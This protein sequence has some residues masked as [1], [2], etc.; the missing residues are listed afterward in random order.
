[1]IWA[2]QSNLYERAATEM[3]EVINAYRKFF[4]KFR[5][6]KASEDHGHRQNVISREN[7][8]WGGEMY[9]S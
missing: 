3:E 5:S 8:V 4:G 2:E 6:R 1:V 7:K 9:S